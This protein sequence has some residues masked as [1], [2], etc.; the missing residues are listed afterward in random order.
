[1]MTTERPARTL[2]LVAPAAVSTLR[3][4]P[5]L[6]P[7]QVLQT[8]GKVAGSTPPGSWQDLNLDSYFGQ[9]TATVRFKEM[10]LPFVWVARQQLI[11]RAGADY[12]AIPMTARANLE[13][14][15]LATLDA[16]CQQGLRAAQQSPKQGSLDEAIELYS[17]Q[18]WRVFCWAHP[19]LAEDLAETLVTWVNSVVR[20][21]QRSS[22]F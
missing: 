21:L 1:M 2:T 19:Y 15:L 20:L 13:G 3:P 14:E 12:Q 16:L 5:S 22:R 4:L 18:G 8:V 6:N 11:A 7:Q 10:L 17:R 9:A